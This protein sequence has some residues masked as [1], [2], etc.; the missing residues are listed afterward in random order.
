MVRPEECTASLTYQV[1][2]GHITCAYGHDHGPRCEFETA[3]P[4][5]FFEILYQLALEDRTILYNR[6]ESCGRERVISRNMF[7]VKARDRT[8]WLKT[9]ARRASFQKKHMRT[10]C[11]WALRNGCRP[12]N[13]WLHFADMDTEAFAPW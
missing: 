8:L 12:D 4:G 1:P 11:E 13:Y 5:R 7:L 3:A 10:I 9:Q 2:G 6:C